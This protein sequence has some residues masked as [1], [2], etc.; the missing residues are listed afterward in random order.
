MWIT[1]FWNEI[2]IQIHGNW[3][4][5]QMALVLDAAQVLMLKDHFS[6]ASF[7]VLSAW[8]KTKTLEGYGRE[9]S[10]VFPGLQLIEVVSESS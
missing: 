9:A 7:G 2:S 8:E 10:N 1:W 3:K 4:E 6:R 5:K